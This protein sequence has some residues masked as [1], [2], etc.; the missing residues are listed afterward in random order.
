MEIRSETDSICMYFCD[1]FVDGCNIIFRCAWQNHEACY[2]AINKF[3]AM[4]FSPVSCYLWVI[5]SVKRLLTSMSMPH[6]NAMCGEVLLHLS[7]IP[8]KGSFAPIS[9]FNNSCSVFEV[10]RFNILESF[11]HCF[12]LFS[13]YYP[14]LR[15]NMCYGS[16]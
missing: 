3:I 13:E 5:Y 4:S 16:Q 15:P 8:V 6:V 2:S 14:S 10:F 9:D 7:F 12:P 11:R 1:W